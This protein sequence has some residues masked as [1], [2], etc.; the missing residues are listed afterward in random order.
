MA[1]ASKQIELSIL[2]ELRYIRLDDTFSS[3]TELSTDEINYF[4]YR[5][6]HKCTTSYDKKNYIRIG[7]LY[8][9]A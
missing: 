8:A 9:V 5:V 6:L 2:F 7:Q 1:S 4:F 3:A